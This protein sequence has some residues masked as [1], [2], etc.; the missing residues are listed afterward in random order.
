MCIHMKSSGSGL[1][2]REPLF[3]WLP[4][5]RFS[6]CLGGRECKIEGCNQ[7]SLVKGIMY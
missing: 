7:T 4:W 2:G 6:L 1:G 3:R 5:F